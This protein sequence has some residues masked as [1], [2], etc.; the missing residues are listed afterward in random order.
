MQACRLALASFGIAHEARVL[1]A[2]RTPKE[3]AR[4]VEALPGRGVRLVIAAAGMAA[5]LAGAV[6]AHTSLPVLAVPLA[7]G[8]LQGIDALFATVQ[9]PGGVPVACFGIGA[10]GAKNAA[11]MAARILALADRD[12]AVRMRG[13]LQRDREQVRK[14]RWP[15]PAAAKGRPS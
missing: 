4:Y 11:Y 15:A 9:M 8:A 7:S 6:A 14:A 3:L 13:V 2:H 12:L 10:A 5:H 1:S